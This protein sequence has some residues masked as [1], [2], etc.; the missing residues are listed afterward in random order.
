MP[1]SNAVGQ[2]TSGDVMA[3]VGPSIHAMQYPVRRGEVFNQLAGILSPRF[4]AGEAE[5]GTKAEFAERLSIAC[6]ALRSALPA[7]LASD[8]RFELR[9]RP[10]AATWVKGRMAMVGDAAHPILPF[11]GQGGCQ[12]LEDAA[13]LGSV[14]GHYGKARAD[15]WIEQALIAF[16]AIR[17]PRTTRIQRE[18]RVFGEVWHFEG[19]AALVRDE[20]FRNL[21]PGDF[22]YTD[23]LYLP[24]FE[25]EPTPQAWLAGQSN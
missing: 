17:R 6:P 3:W 22:R 8:A 25:G 21:V 19:A 2:E 10:P 18:T 5:W 13:A 16:E 11:V 4:L 24:G 1:W 12:A 20:L 23:R 7:L 9:E 15:G 14:V